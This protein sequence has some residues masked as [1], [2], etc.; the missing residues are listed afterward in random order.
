MLWN[1]C[2]R[3]PFFRKTW[4]DYHEQEFDKI[5]LRMSLRVSIRHLS[6]SLSC[7]GFTQGIWLVVEALCS[8][9]L[10][11]LIFFLVVHFEVKVLNGIHLLSYPESNFKAIV[12]NHIVLIHFIYRILIQYIY[13]ILSI[14]ILFFLPYP[15]AT[16]IK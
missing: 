12:T 4:T 14:Y 8:R 5:V 1:L 7:F 11:N 3:I 15:V 16:P 6:L 10:F 9:S 13:Y 2:K